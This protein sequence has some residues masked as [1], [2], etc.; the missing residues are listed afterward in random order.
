MLI[1]G[2]HFLG[3]R[4]L[5]RRLGEQ[6]SLRDFL[7]VEHCQVS[8]RWNRVAGDDFLVVAFDDSANCTALLMDAT[9]TSL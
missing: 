6:C 2:A 1:L 9:R 5:T 4:H 8:A 3:F 7:A